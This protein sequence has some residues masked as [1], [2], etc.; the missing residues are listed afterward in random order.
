MFSHRSVDRKV[1]VSEVWERGEGGEDEGRRGVFLFTMMSCPRPTATLSLRT[2]SLDPIHLSGPRPH[3]LLSHNTE[4]S[5]ASSPTGRHKPSV[6]ISYTHSLSLFSSQQLLSHNT[7]PSNR[8][9]PKP[10]SSALVWSLIIFNWE[11]AGHKACK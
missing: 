7:K 8:T 11:K 4:R 2:P 9:R 5:V 10:H 1:R 6:T 3:R